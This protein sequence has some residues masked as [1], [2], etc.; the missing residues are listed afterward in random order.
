MG[1]GLERKRQMWMGCKPCW[2]ESV[3]A[4]VEQRMAKLNAADVF[5]EQA[6]AQTQIQCYTP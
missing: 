2:R 4:Y 1:D 3:C 5:P 6:V